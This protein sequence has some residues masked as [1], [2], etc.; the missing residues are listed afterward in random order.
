MSVIK[1]FSNM[2][3]SYF[4]LELRLLCSGGVFQYKDNKAWW[5]ISIFSEDAGV[6]LKCI[7]IANIF[8]TEAG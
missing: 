3:G 5:L 4:Y 7:Q 1:E 6:L 2:T 8:S